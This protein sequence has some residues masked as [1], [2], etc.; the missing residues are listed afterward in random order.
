VLTALDRIYLAEGPDEPD[1]GLNVAY[2][3]GRLS[4]QR[5]VAA[6][7]WRVPAAT[8]TTIRDATAA[9]AAMTRPGELERQLQT[10]PGWVLRLLDRRDP[11]RPVSERVAAS[12]R[13]S[14]AAVPL[15]RA[16]G[17][18]GPCPAL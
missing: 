6:E 18:A 8:A 13:R 1:L 4:L 16:L 7:A 10:F 11:S 12:R 15:P 2:V 5:F 17:Q 14:D 9:M 3:G